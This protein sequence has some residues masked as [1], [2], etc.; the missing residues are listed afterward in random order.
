MTTA[1]RKPRK[2]A[3]KRTTSGSAANGSAA[4]SVARRSKVLEDTDI[5]RL[6]Q[7]EDTAERFDLFAIDDDIHTARSDIPPNEMLQVIRMMRTHSEVEAGLFLLELILEEDSFDALIHFPFKDGQFK[8]VCD[9]A[10]DRVIGPMPAGK[11]RGRNG[12]RTRRG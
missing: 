4:A 8:Q 2:A 1:T 10:Y 11:A 12:S 6:E 9:R 7:A 3:V 5:I